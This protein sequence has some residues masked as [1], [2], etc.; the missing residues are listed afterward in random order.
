[1]FS[2]MTAY[3]PYVEDLL[4]E[5]TH[6]II[7]LFTDH[8]TSYPTEDPTADYPT[9]NP[10][11]DQTIE[12][13]LEPTYNPTAPT[14]EP[15]TDP[16]EASSG[17]TS[18]EFTNALN[19]FIFAFFAG[20]IFAWSKLLLPLINVLVRGS[21]NKLERGRTFGVLSS[22]ES[23]CT[24]GGPLAI[25]YLCGTKWPISAFIVCIV[26]VIIGFI[27]LFIKIKPIIMMNGRIPAFE[28]WNANGGTNERTSYDANIEVND[29]R[30]QDLFD[31]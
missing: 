3:K 21:S 20:L 28:V 25:D 30:H 11:V 27:W 16:S 23:I 9:W 26:L 8:T 6:G 15:T 13:T 10:T 4:E 7:D 17:S 22:I 12:P 14:M 31:L 29:N 1:M 18:S 19:G 24:Y 2:V 5:K